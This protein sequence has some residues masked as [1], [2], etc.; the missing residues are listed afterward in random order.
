MERWY[1]IL[2]NL[3]HWVVQALFT[4]LKHFGSPLVFLWVLVA[5]LFNLV[6]FAMFVFA[7]CLVFQ[8]VLVSLDCPLL[9][10]PS[11][12]SYVYCNVKRIFYKGLSVN[13]S[14]YFNTCYVFVQWFIPA[15]SL[16]Y[17]WKTSEK[18]NEWFF[19]LDE[20]IYTFYEWSFHCRGFRFLTRFVVWLQMAFA[21]IMFK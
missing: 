4:L 20:M 6:F 9:I 11:I 14:Q 17:K 15:F 19:F 1:C 12:S 7:L 13:F 3:I 21:C 18:N 16:N 8:M 10:V 2:Y 5:H